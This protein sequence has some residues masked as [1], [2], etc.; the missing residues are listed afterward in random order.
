[1]PAGPWQQPVLAVEERASLPSYTELKTSTVKLAVVEENDIGNLCER[2]L[3][4]SHSFDIQHIADPAGQL[5]YFCYGPGN[6]KCKGKQI[7][8]E[9]ATLDIPLRSPGQHRQRKKHD[10]NFQI[11]GSC[12]VPHPHHAR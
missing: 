2:S 4:F 9:L 6:R 8:R 5:Y 12:D 7:W 3:Y 10:G 1:V 11:H